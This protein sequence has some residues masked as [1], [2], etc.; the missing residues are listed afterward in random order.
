VFFSDGEGFGYEIMS[1]LYYDSG[2]LKSLLVYKLEEGVGCSE[3]LEVL[4]GYVVRGQSGSPVFDEENKVVGVVYGV[5]G[6]NGSEK[7]IVTG[8]G[9]IKSFL[10]E[11]IE[12]MK[13][14]KS[15]SSQF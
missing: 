10:R 14:V 4:D 11:Y 9:K 7:V 12:I 2:N 1:R 8:F 5:L 3:N 13:L 6:D 15:C